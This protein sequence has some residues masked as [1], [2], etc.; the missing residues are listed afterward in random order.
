MFKAESNADSFLIGFVKNIDLEKVYPEYFKN[1]DKKEL[2]R[3]LRPLYRLYVEQE[4]WRVGNLVICII[5]TVGLGKP[6]SKNVFTKIFE[7]DKEYNW[8]VGNILSNFIIT[9]LIFE[10]WLEE[11]EELVYS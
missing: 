9:E 1:N 2:Y 7:L 11:L 4:G 3:K 6:I 8:T 5:V 10:H